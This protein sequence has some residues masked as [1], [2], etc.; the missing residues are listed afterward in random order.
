MNEQSSL[1]ISLAEKKLIEYVERQ[2]EFAGQVLGLAQWVRVVENPSQEEW[3]IA[4]ELAE[5]ICQKCEKI[6][7]L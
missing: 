6:I 1:I 3:K 4:K 7:G 5:L 2:Q